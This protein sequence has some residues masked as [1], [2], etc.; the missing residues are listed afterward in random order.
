MLINRQ[1][2]INDVEAHDNGLWIT[3]DT[4]IFT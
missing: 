3:E 1:M 2:S 4:G